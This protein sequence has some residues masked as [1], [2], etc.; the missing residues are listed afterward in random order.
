MATRFRGPSTRGSSGRTPRRP[1]W[2]AGPGGSSAPSSSGTT[3][4]GTSAVVASSDV[5][6]IR[7]RGEFVVRLRSASAVNNGFNGAVG[8][9]VVNEN[10]AGVGI[11][12]VPHPITDVA[13]DGW[14]W[15]QFF[16]VKAS[17][18]AVADN[19]PAYPGN[20]W[21]RYTID[22]KAMRRMNLADNIVAVMEVTLVGTATMDT[23]FDTRILTK[24]MV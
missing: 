21:A 24:I 6:L 11:T 16:S 13:W 19:E 18:G 5:T 1:G 7:T 12:A 22:S 3:L 2:S 20:Q 4:F 15:Y 9:C 8:I 17:I 23:Q 10:A 14:L